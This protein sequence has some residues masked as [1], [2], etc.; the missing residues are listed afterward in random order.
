MDSNLLEVLLSEYRALK[1]EQKNLFS[2]QFTLISIWLT[3][4]GVLLGIIFDKVSSIENDMCGSNINNAFQCMITMIQKSDILQLIFLV[5]IPATFAIFSI[6]WL[7]LVTRFLKEAHY[8]FIIETKLQNDFPSFVGFDHF[9]YSEKKKT[10]FKI[11]YIYYLF[12][13]FFILILVFIFPLIIWCNNLSQGI[14]DLPYFF[15]FVGFEIPFIAALCFYL[16]QISY[17]NKQKKSIIYEQM[18]SNKKNKKSNV[19]HN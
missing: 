3:F 1:D 8:I 9:V 19:K 18:I 10:G 2:L 13:I 12:V 11:S 4:F 15:V 16:A 7:D 6:I 14:Y 17:Y 5:L